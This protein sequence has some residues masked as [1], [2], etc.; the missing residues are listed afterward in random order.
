MTR[1]G[2]TALIA[3]CIAL[4]ACGGGSSAQQTPTQPQPSQVPTASIASISPS[5]AVTGTS[6]LPLKIVGSNFVSDSHYFSQVLWTANGNSTSLATSLVS[7]TQITA[8]I[9]ADLLK[10]PVTVQVS[11]QTLD[12]DGIPQTTSNAV[13]FT[14]NAPVPPAVS[15]SSDTLG[16]KG[17]R[18]FVLVIDGKSADAV[19]SVQEGAIGGTITPTGL[20]AVPDHPGIFHVIAIST[21]DPSKNATATVAVVASGFTFAGNM[22]TPRAS[23]TA[24]LL[25]DGKVLIAGGLQED[26]GNTSVELF[27]PATGTFTPTGSMTTFRGGATAILLGNGKVLIAGGLGAADGGT[28]LPLLKTAEIYDPLSGTFSATGSM[29]VGRIEH[30]ATLLSN[31]KVLIAG[32]VDSHGGGGAATESAELY[33]PSAGTFTLIGSMASERA[34]HTATLLSSGEVFIVGGW[35]GH[36]ADSIDDP[37]W[38]PLFA[39]LYN[40]MSS[41][42]TST[43]L[44]STTRFGHTATRLLDGRV[45]LLG[46]IPQVQN[47]HIELPAPAYAEVYDPVSGGFS[48]AGNFAVSRSSYT[49][50]L[51]TNGLVLLTG[52]SQAGLAVASA[53]LFDPSSSS[54]VATG[55]LLNPRLGHTATRL[56]DGRVLVTGGNGSDGNPLATAE[57]YK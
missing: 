21:A 8:V 23:H 43:G 57:L 52:G 9:R 7:G 14:I 2:V 15:P 29:S 30:T 10:T 39:E 56:I 45:L 47:L 17:A 18:Q 48:P 4:S 33:D 1:I 12:Q 32:G 5:N 3:L 20:Y 49:T 34:E 25:N 11:V 19:W 16:P 22:T 53:D 6:D 24:T 51:L 41:G 13:S 27:D 50:T 38:D 35:N 36:R 28:F 54:S 42:F 31:G 44:S 37:P 46:G 40:P 55:G 26:T